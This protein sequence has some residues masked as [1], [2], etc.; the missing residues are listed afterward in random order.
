MRDLL[1][2]AVGSDVLTTLTMVPLPRLVSPGLLI[3]VD[4]YAMRGGAG[5]RLKR[6][7]FDIPGLASLPEAVCHGLRCE[8]FI[9]ISGQSAL[10]ERGEILFGADLPSQNGHR[11]HVPRFSFSRFRSL[12]PSSAMLTFPTISPPHQIQRNWTT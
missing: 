10:D 1:A 7:P 2:R 8:K 5:R 4:G 6:V 3:A 9:F 12:A 11:S